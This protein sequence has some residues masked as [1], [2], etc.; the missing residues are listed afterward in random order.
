MDGTTDR[1]VII[2][3]KK[4][5]AKTSKPNKQQGSSPLSLPVAYENEL[6]RLIQISAYILAEEDGFRQSPTHYW[7]IAEEKM[8]L[9]Y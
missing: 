3:T 1:R 8:V 7:L 2:M 9:G 4:I 6:H 5:V